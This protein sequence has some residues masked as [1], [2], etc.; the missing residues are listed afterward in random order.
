MALRKGGVALGKGGVWHL[1]RRGV[2]L[3]KGGVWHL[4]RRGVALG[5]GG[6]WHLGRR[7]VA[8]GKGGVWHLGRRGVA[9][10]SLILPAQ[11][12]RPSVPG[13][14]PHGVR[15][16]AR[17]QVSCVHHSAVSLRASW[18]AGALPVDEPDAGRSHGH[19]LQDV[20]E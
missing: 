6:V 17:D 3:G 16:G 4:G 9:I 19:L 8:V 18:D 7:G 2:A 1:G 10:G 11:V 12:V 13:D 15:S 20:E 14:E 5:K